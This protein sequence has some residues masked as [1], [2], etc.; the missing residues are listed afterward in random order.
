M[1]PYHIL[2]VVWPPI[3]AVLLPFCCP[4]VR[5]ALHSLKVWLVLLHDPPQDLPLNL[6]RKLPPSKRS[7][8][9]LET[10]SE[11]EQEQQ[12]VVIDA[13]PTP[14]QVIVMQRPSNYK[15]NHCTAARLIDGEPPPA[16]PV[17]SACDVVF[18][19][20]LIHCN[21]CHAGGGWSRSWSGP[22]SG[23]AAS[24]AVWWA[25]PQQGARRTGS[26]AGQGSWCTATSRT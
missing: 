10:E 26:Q 23:T 11:E 21:C 5:A 20:L 18:A 1:T 14:P 19:A 13:D 22:R 7:R 25:G 9:V 12:V 2:L 24:R 3:V 17:M 6:P 4:P 15:F 16:W 8:A